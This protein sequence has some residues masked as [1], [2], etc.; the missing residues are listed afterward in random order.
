MFLLRHFAATAAL[1]IAAAS[2]A[3]PPSPVRAIYTEIA[4]S[5][6]SQVPGLPVGTRFESLDRPYRSPDG[7]LFI[8]RVTTTDP[9]ATDDIILVGRTRPENGA[10]VSNAVV[11]EGQPLGFGVE[12]NG[13]IDRNLGINNNGSFV[14]ATNSDGPVA[15]DEYVIKFDAA[16]ATFSAAAQEGQAAPGIANATFGTILEAGSI[17]GNGNVAHGAALAGV[18]AAQNFAIYLAAVPLAQKGVTVPAGQ[19][20]GGARAWEFFDSQDFYTND[21][22]THWIADGDLVGAPNTT[23]DVLVVDG[24]VK[25]QEGF[26]VPGSGMASPVAT[27]GLVDHAMMSNGDWFARGNNADGGDWV[28]RN[29]ALLRKTGDPVPG[30]LPGETFSNALFADTF[31][32]AVG[33]NNGDYCYGGTTSNPDVNRDAVIVFNNNRV[34][35]RQGDPVDVNGDGLN[36]DDAFIDIFNNQDAFLTDDLW[37]FFTADIKNGA[38]AALGQAFCR[39]RVALAFVKQPAAEH[40]ALVCWPD[41]GARA[42][43]LQAEGIVF[44]FELARALDVALAGGF[45]EA[46]YQFNQCFGGG[47]IDELFDAATYPAITAGDMSAASAS[48]HDEPSWSHGGGCAGGSGYG[49][50][51]SRVVGPPLPFPSRLAFLFGER[52]DAF[53]P[54]RRG[55]EDPQYQSTGLGGDFRRI[56]LGPGAMPPFHRA[57]LFVGEPTGRADYAADVRRIHQKLRARGY[58]AADIQVLYGAGGANLLCQAPIGG[59][60]IPFT[61][62]TRNDLIAPGAAIDDLVPAGSVGTDEYY[63]WFHDHGSRWRFA[64]GRGGG[65]PMAIPLNGSHPRS[66]PVPPSFR[67]LFDGIHKRGRVY[68]KVDSGSG[69]GTVELNGAV[70]FSGPFFADDNV[71]PFTDGVDAVVLEGDNVIT[72]T[73]TSGPTMIISEL[74]LGSDSIPS[75]VDSEPFDQ[76]YIDSQYPVFGRCTV[77]P[78]CL[79]G[80]LQSECSAAGGVFEAGV[81]CGEG[82]AGCAGDSDCD[83]DVDFN[84]I[85]FFVAALSGE[86]SWVNIHLVIFGVAPSCPYSD[87][88]VDGNGFVDFGDI[89][90]FIARIGSVCP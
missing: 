41:A 44:D 34:I 84:D 60:V 80:V 19:L 37:Y 26:V 87:N 48:R 29:G 58:A 38:G 88:D 27:N 65:P 28:V 31:F 63:L 39:V 11:V 70:I 7:S 18:P 50:P 66:V 61:R 21:A 68:C 4:A 23:D 16:T 43:S 33:N 49:W 55:F 83:G 69:A 74:A 90:A 17:T 36:N 78:N 59:G 14:Y 24:T 20:D 64:A 53:G 13:P 15:S 52:F 46:H 8:I 9:A 67:R 5:P 77:G 89:D 47:M 57:L 79:D 56:G 1:A 73:N 45:D 51:Y 32:L 62:A 75:N 40:S 3:A 54:Y 12:N 72:I 22:G 85:D 35:L 10:I 71:F 30:G 82:P 81:L 25:I 76:P 6:T 2:W 86:S 42:R